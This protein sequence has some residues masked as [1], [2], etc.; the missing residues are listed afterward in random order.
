MTTMKFILS[1][2]IVPLMLMCLSGC[3]AVPTEIGRTPTMPPGLPT[4][5]P[6][7][8]TATPIPPTVTPT[9]PT[10]TPMPPLVEIPAG[11]FAMGSE[12]G[13][14][15]ERPVHDVYLDGFFIDRMEVTNV[16]FAEFLNEMGNQVEG[17]ENWLD[18]DDEDCLI[19]DRAGHFQHKTGFARHPVIEVTWYGARGM[20]G[21]RTMPTP[22][23]RS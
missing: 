12:I 11:E 15:D 21:S 5:T 4:R 2:A 6:A 10:P 22:I 18:I 9:G 16:Q 8:P 19:F 17:G 7:P 3:G 20:I 13:L 23:G 1:V 14:S